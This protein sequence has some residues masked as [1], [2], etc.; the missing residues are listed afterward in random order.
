M[1]GVHLALDRPLSLS[2]IDTKLAHGVRVALIGGLSALA[3][4]ALARLAGRRDGVASA[5]RAAA[6]IGWSAAASALF[7]CAWV[8]GSLGAWPLDPLELYLPLLA[9]G[10]AAPALLAMGLVL[11]ATARSR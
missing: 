4:F 2:A 9:L 11:V 3:L 10:A 7:A 5:R 1:V 6:S 8:G